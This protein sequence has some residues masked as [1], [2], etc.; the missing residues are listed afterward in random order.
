MR[1][2]EDLLAWIK[3]AN[4][5]TVTL[6]EDTIQLP[7]LR[8][9]G[10]P[11]GDTS[12]F[13]ILSRCVVVTQTGAILERKDL[14]K[15]EGLSYRTQFN[16]DVWPS[17]T[18]EQLIEVRRDLQ[19]NSLWESVVKPSDNATTKTL[20]SFTLTPD[21]TDVTVGDVVTIAISDVV[22][23]GADIS[24]ITLVS[25]DETVAT[26]SG[27]TVTTNLEGTVTITATDSNTGVTSTLEITI[28]ASA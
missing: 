22:A 4:E 8:E 27:L 26:V 19:V 1:N 25:D 12:T 14:L 16:D 20:T 15:C 23:V 17:L 3:S 11:I 24:G 5:Y 28:N 9:V 10:E 7:I 13:E 18:R 21:S 6:G 2:R